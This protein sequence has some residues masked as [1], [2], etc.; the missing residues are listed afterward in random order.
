MDLYLIPDNP[1]HTVLASPNGT[2]HYQIRTM[3]RPRISV[4]Q[5]PA[6]C[7][8]ESVVAEIEWGRWDSPSMIRSPLLGKSGEVVGQEG[9]GMFLRNFLFKRSR[10][11]HSRYFVSNDGTEYK[12][13]AERHVGLVLSQV[14]TNKEIAR[15]SRGMVK[16]GIFAGEKRGV[17]QIQPCTL[18]IDLIVLSFLI[19]EKKRRDRR[20]DGT[21]LTAHD[22]DPQGDGGFSGGEAGDG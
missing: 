3:R 17:L 6:D 7:E 22:E 15:Y 14:G 13:K 1:E 12:W 21:R 2:A 11:G 9:I 19:V 10:F 8:E 4:L 5:R 20:G 16:Q 18:D